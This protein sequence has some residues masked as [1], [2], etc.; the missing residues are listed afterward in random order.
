MDEGVAAAASMACSKSLVAEHLVE[1]VAAARLGAAAPSTWLSGA[2]GSATLL[3]DADA[4]WAAAVALLRM[5]R[6]AEAE[7]LQKRVARLLLPR[8]RLV[9][10]AT[11]RL[12]FG[13]P[14]LP[15]PQEAAVEDA[16]TIRL[17]RRL[18]LALAVLLAELSQTL[19]GSSLVPIKT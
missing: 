4:T 14:Q 9:S 19:S 13:S 1:V 3:R 11:S 18:R 2:R 12:S 15:L 17:V 8:L 10:R 6:A 5:H 7:R 16:D